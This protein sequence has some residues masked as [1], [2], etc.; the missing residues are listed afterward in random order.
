MVTSVVETPQKLLLSASQLV[1]TG[2]KWARAAVVYSD[3][4]TSMRTTLRQLFTEHCSSFTIRHKYREEALQV[5]E[6]RE[7]ADPAMEDLYRINL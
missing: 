3:K 4:L 6:Y 7:V 1:W 2:T 5:R